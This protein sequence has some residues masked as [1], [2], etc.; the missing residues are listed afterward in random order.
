MVRR[1]ARPAKEPALMV[2][3]SNVDSLTGPPMSAVAAA[4][5]AAAVA[6]NNLLEDQYFAS[7]KRKDCRLMKANENLNNC[8]NN[9]GNSKTTAITKP[10]SGRTIGKY[11]SFALCYIFVCILR[12]THFTPTP[13]HVNLINLFRRSTG[14]A[15]ANTHD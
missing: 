15:L 6:S 4:A 1:R 11:L 10:E 14:N 2:V 13:P 7:P 8:N 12:L 3:T 5:A 9:N